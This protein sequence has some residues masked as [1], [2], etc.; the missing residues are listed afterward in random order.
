MYDF[1]EL[2]GYEKAGDA[3]FHIYVNICIF[4]KT[5]CNVCCLTVHECNKIYGSYI[6]RKVLI[7]KFIHMCDTG[8]KINRNLHVAFSVRS[9]Y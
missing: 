2:C 7:N 1:I 8:S 5:M 4:S 3:S 6:S 9:L